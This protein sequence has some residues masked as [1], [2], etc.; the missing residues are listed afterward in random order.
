MC[1]EEKGRCIDAVELHVGWL[2]FWPREEYAWEQAPF[3]ER[4]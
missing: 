4:W 2:H 3:D 1:G